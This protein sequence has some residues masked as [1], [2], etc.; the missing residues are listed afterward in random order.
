MKDQ[1]KS[2]DASHDFQH[3]DRVRKLALVLGSREG[4][5]DIELVEIA[6]L[7]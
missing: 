7:V 2:Y 1:L 6:A 4:V 5:E 3:V